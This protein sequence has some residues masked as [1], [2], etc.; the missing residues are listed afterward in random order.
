M[1]SGGGGGQEPDYAY[2]A[3]MAKL[4]EEQSGWAKEFMN[5]YKTG[6]FET[7]GDKGTDTGNYTSKGHR[8]LPEGQYH[9]QSGN[10]WTRTP[11]GWKDANGKTHEVNL[12][13]NLS[14]VS[15]APGADIQ[16]TG[17]T[18]GSSVG[19]LKNPDGSDVSYANLELKQIGANM[20]MLPYETRQ[21]KAEAELAALRSEKG[22]DLVD[23]EVAAVKSKYQLERQT[24][25]TAAMSDAYARSRLGAENEAANEEMG[26]AARLRPLMEGQEGAQYTYGKTKAEADT[27]LIAPWADTMRAQYGY[28]TD[29]YKYDKAGIAL[30][31]PV[32]DKYFA[33]VDKGVD[34]NEKVNQASGDVAAGFAGAEQR[35]ARNLAKYGINPN[36]GRGKNEFS[37]TGLQ[38]GKTLAGARTGARTAA[39]EETF[40]RRR[41]AMM[42]AY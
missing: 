37:Q 19:G 41:E 5:F 2:N 15:L 6:S 21:A 40:R 28:E 12:D 30:R 1:S 29:K 18:E 16:Y 34:V 7:P 32:R 33:E 26:K 39:E 42:G 11:G 23:D 17:G 38:Y 22:R 24:A 35:T 31:T 36:S 20:E 4:A 3:R 8:D 13:G 14:N 25:D 10:L 27:G 9:D